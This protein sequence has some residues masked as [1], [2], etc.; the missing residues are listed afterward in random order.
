MSLTKPDP[1]TA[2]EACDG[3]PTTGSSQTVNVPDKSDDADA[4]TIAA[5]AAVKQSAPARPPRGTLRLTFMVRLEDAHEVLLELDDRTNFTH[6][7]TVESV[8]IVADKVQKVFEAL[9]MEPLLTAANQYVRARQDAA[10][11]KAGE[12][13]KKRSK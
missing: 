6:G 13:V 7:A 5:D 12:A 9:V 1:L 8:A 2:T 3:P 10:Q 11:P 4:T